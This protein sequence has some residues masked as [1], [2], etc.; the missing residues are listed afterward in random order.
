MNEDL[1]NQYIAYIL[2]GIYP[3]MGAPTPNSPYSEFDPEVWLQAFEE[4][5]EDY[6]L[7][8]DEYNIEVQGCDGLPSNIAPYL[9]E[10]FWSQYCPPPPVYI[11]TCNGVQIIESECDCWAN[12]TDYMSFGWDPNPGCCYGCMDPDDWK[13]RPWATC[14][15]QEAC[16]NKCG[17][18]EWP[19]IEKWNEV[20]FDNTGPWG[21]NVGCYDDEGLMIDA[22]GNLV[23]TPW[24]PDE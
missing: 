11:E 2:Q 1:L 18:G 20:S 10:D 15:V 24:N 9:P 12:G 8:R 3:P 13:Y 5:Y 23:T 7:L 6:H 14:H 19:W 4:V 17:G 22:M 21:G 16:K